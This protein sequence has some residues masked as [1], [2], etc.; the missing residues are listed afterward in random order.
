M[1]W[2]QNLKEL[3][4][5]K[6]KNPRD[7]LAIL[8][9]QEVESFQKLSEVDF[10][11]IKK[12]CHSISSS[13]VNKKDLE[14]VRERLREV[15]TR[16]GKRKI[17][18]S[19]KRNAEMIFFSILRRAREERYDVLHIQSGQK[20]VARQAGSLKVLASEA[21][22]DESDILDLLSE[23]LNP[24]SYAK[25]LKGKHA[26]GSLSIPGISRFKISAHFENRKP[27]L[28]IRQIPQ[29]IPETEEIDLFPGFMDLSLPPESGLIL[30]CGSAITGKST[31]CA[32][33]LEEWNKTQACRI[34]CLEDPIEYLFSDK[35]ANI[36][37][38]EL[39]S[40]ISSMEQGAQQAVMDGAQI[41]FM[42]SIENRKDLDIALNL[43]ESGMLVLSTVQ[44][45]TC[46]GALEFMASLLPSQGTRATYQNR[47]S[48]TLKV[49][50]CQVLVP[51]KTGGQFAVREVLKMDP[52]ARTLVRDNNLVALQ[53]YMHQA[54]EE[55]TISYHRQFMRLLEEGV[56]DLSE[57]IDWIPD[58]QTFLSRIQGYSF[59]G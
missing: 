34:L 6:V 46:Q 57:V 11:S 28:S 30:I 5:K 37:Q 16:G 3:V 17:R 39:Y 40:D 44:A 47:L 27:G 9:Q 41:L 32:A 59:A 54:V 31:T 7:I 8:L 50:M 52:G 38:R 21:I 53:S 23:V 43:S 13:S 14:L 35:K 51:T 22:Y 49:L 55:G 36:V 2:I 24:E 10:V 29:V 15:E 4:R 58:H 12:I 20:P 19:S 18:F 48:N 42:S 25:F 26:S 1:D 56:L 45:E 33:L